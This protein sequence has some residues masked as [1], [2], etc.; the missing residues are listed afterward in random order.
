MHQTLEVCR[1]DKQKRKLYFGDVSNNVVSRAFFE[2]QFSTSSAQTD[3][4]TL[5]TTLYNIYRFNEDLSTVKL[6]LKYIPAILHLQQNLNKKLSKRSFISEPITALGQ[7]LWQI[8]YYRNSKDYCRGKQR[9][10]E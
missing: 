3:I 1:V 6:D 8:L 7:V 2:N 4:K 5:I 10:I 9:F